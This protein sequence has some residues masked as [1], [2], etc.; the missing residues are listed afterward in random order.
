MWFVLSRFNNAGMGAPA[1]P[2]EDLTFEEWNNVVSANLTGSFL[3]TQQA[4]KIM[5]SQSPMGG[6]IINNG[7]IS[8]DRPRPNSSPYTATKHAIS[9]LTKSTSLVSPETSQSLVTLPQLLPAHTHSAYRCGVQNPMYA[10]VHVITHLYRAG[11]A[12]V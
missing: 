8:A 11:W 3:C 1:K 2:L 12:Q 5:K 7:S 9:G 6:R 10:G 4:F